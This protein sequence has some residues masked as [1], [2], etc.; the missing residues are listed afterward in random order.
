MHGQFD[1]GQADEGHGDAD[2]GQGQAEEMEMVQFMS[3]HAAFQPVETLGQGELAALV[4]DYPS[5][6]GSESRPAAVKYIAA[7][8]RLS[9]RH[10]AKT[11]KSQADAPLWSS[12]PVPSQDIPNAYSRYDDV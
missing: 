4:H 11:A 9:H 12:M 2:R 5:R 8:G 6:D 7:H 1:D 10:A 3:L